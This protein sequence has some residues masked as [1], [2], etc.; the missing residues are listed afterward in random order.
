MKLDEEFERK[1]QAL[2]DL[3]DKDTSFVKAVHW[4]T[5]VFIVLTGLVFGFTAHAISTARGAEGLVGLYLIAAISGLAFFSA[6]LSWLD[7]MLE[8]AKRYWSQR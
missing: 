3:K 1:A 4:A 8:L 2:A 5:V 6:L 7:V